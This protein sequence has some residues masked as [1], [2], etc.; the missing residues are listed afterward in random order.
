MA[1]IDHTTD[2]RHNNISRAE[3][4]ARV[5]HDSHTARTTDHDHVAEPRET[6]SSG[7]NWIII[8]AAVVLGL[9]LLAWLFGAFAA[10]ETVAVTPTTD[11]EIVATET[12]TE[13]APVT[14][15][16]VEETAGTAVSVESDVTTTT[17]P[18]VPVD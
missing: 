14:A 8:A 17:V 2:P 10:D 12:A 9:L 1:S 15:V 13:T 6:H 16:A 5:P 7:T 3:V 4:D 11:A 18:V